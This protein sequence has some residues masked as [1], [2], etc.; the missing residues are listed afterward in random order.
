MQ[1]LAADAK[2]AQAAN[3]IKASGEGGGWEIAR[4]FQALR[5]RDARR[6]ADAEKRI[7]EAARR[8]DKKLDETVSRYISTHPPHTAG[9]AA[10]CRNCLSRYMCLMPSRHITSNESG[11]RWP[12]IASLCAILDTLGQ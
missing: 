12:E 9:L 6:V 11:K 8:I 1:Q 4:G 7:D 5:E 10:A 3:D 2:K